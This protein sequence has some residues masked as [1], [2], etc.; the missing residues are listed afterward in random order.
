MEFTVKTLK[1][2]ALSWVALALAAS[3]GVLGLVLCMG[4]DG[5]IAVEMAHRGRCQGQAER[6]NHGTHAVPMDVSP[7]AS[8]AG[9]GDCIDVALSVEN[10]LRYVKEVRYDR[11]LKGT[12]L[13]SP[14]AAGIALNNSDSGAAGATALRGE[15]ASLQSSLLSQRTIVLRI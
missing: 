10:L 6:D 4:A 2:A 3:G 13:R 14:T 1:I 5:H 12:V 11:P 15:P 7:T 9:C 8:A